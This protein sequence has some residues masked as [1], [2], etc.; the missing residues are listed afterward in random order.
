MILL[1]CRG[2]TG[3]IYVLGVP[4]R[5]IKDHF[6]FIK[7]PSCTIYKDVCIRVLSIDISLVQ[8]LPYF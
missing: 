7:S 4:M 1:R 5:T 6:I 2:E 3:L 8:F